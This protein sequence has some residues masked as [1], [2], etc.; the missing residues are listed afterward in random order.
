M[1]VLTERGVTDSLIFLPEHGLFW[2]S[3]DFCILLLVQLCHSLSDWVQFRNRLCTPP[4]QVLE[5]GPHSDQE[6]FCAV[7]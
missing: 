7:K 4:L 2:Q 1:Q 5:Q 3:L 6:P